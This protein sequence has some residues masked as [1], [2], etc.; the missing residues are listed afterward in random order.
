MS[1]SGYND[2]FNDEI[3]QMICWRGAVKSAIRGRRGQAFLVE[4]LHALDSL[5]EKRLVS[6]DLQ[7][8]HG[9]VCAIG[10]VGVSRGM[11]VSKLDPEDYSSVAAEF[12]I[13]EALTRE[14]VFENDEVSSRETPEQRFERMR[15]W[16]ESLVLDQ[17]PDDRT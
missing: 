7:D 8:A 11:A 2:Y 4:M 13:S 3:W 6:G 5:P 9:A 1:R 15:Q 17:S 16:V 10:A 12:N 14:I